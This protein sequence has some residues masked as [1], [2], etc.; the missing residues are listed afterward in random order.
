EASLPQR[1]AVRSSARRSWLS[2]PVTGTNP[3][4]PPRSQT[5]AEG[6]RSFHFRSSDDFPMKATSSK[7]MG[8]SLAMADYEHDT[9]PVKILLLAAGLAT[10]DA[11]GATE[12]EYAILR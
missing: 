4:S 11:L 10:F 12:S 3:R 9:G 6:R 1:C 2:F 7:P 8:L 5:T